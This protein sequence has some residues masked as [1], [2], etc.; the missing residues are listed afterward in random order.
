MTEKTAK[1][2][3]MP[4]L[5]P[6]PDGR[7]ALLSGGMPGNAGGGRLPDPIKEGLREIAR[8]D[9]VP[10]LRRIVQGTPLMPTIGVCEACG[11]E[12]PFS[13]EYAELF[14]TRVKVNEDHRLKASDIILKVVGN[15][16]EVLITDPKAVAFFDLVSLAATE[17]FGAEGAATL[18]RRVT[19]LADGV[20]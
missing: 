18:Y 13:E 1:K 7:G 5:V 14:L 6:R 4:V 9:V 15:T 12:Q 19:E 2:S 8:D 20:K 16:K 10:H 11:H 3:A 17:I